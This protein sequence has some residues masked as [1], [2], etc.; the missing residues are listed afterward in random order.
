MR[1]R[2]QQPPYSSDS[3]VNGGSAVANASTLR[4]VCMTVR[5]GPTIATRPRPS[6]PAVDSVSRSR[7]DGG[8]TAAELA[9]LL[10]GKPCVVT[11]RRRV[12]P[13]PPCGFDVNANRGSICFLVSWDCAG[14]PIATF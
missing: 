3:V 12:I 10:V 7:Y 5:S 14:R 1:G 6:Q 4:P 13:G 11:P 8:S 9:A 2:H